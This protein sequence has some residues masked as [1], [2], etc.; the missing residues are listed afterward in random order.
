MFQ[1]NTP[2]RSIF[3]PVLVRDPVYLSAPRL[4]DH[5]SWARLREQSRSHLVPWEDDWSPEEL[6]FSFYRRRLKLFE[7]EAARGGALSL[8]VFARAERALVGGV[9]LTNIRYGSARSGIVGYWIGKPFVRR[10]YGTAAVGA[11]TAHAFE[12]IGLNRL[13]AACQPDNAASRRL[14][15]KCGFHREGRAKDYLRINGEWRDHDIFAMTARDFRGCDMAQ[16]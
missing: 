2:P 15:V 8:F 10:G 1:Q 13:E 9:T 7:R 12:A 6:D 11:L 14:L 5:A 3:D 16:S 4:E